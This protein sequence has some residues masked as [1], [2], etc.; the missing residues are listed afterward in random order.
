MRG[1]V[2]KSLGYLQETIK[3]PLNPRVPMAPRCS[4]LDLIDNIVRCGYFG[5]RGQGPLNRFI[6]GEPQSSPQRCRRNRRSERNYTGLEDT[7]NRS[8]RIHHDHVHVGPNLVS[9][10]GVR[11][12]H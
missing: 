6:A 1:R 4:R 7:R 3:Y 12:D 9:E 10:R 11:G 5:A 8:G 2:S